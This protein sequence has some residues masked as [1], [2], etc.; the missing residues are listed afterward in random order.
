SLRHAA[1]TYQLNVLGLDPDDVAK[2]L[3]H[4]SGVQVWEMYVRVRPQLFGRAADASR[5]AG[6]PRGRPS[7]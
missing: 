6:D 1:A 3:G 2:F 7:D 5:Q 4:R